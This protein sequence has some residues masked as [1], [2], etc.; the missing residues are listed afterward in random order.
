M[1][2]RKL[3]AGFAAAVCPMQWTANITFIPR[4]NQIDARIQLKTLFGIRPRAGLQI[5]L[6]YG[7]FANHL[8]ISQGIARTA[9]YV[10]P[11]SP[12]IVSRTARG[13]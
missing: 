10:D 1:A 6:A 12:G 11:N 8:S 3:V 7:N 13:I 2:S 5:L 4:I 9:H